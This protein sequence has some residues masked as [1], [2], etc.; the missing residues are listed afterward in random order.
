MCDWIKSQTAFVFIIHNEKAL[1]C[2]VRW[3][4]LRPVL[5]VQLQLVL[6]LG[7]L[8]YAMSTERLSQLVRV[9]EGNAYKP[10]TRLPRSSEILNLL[11]LP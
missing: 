2:H 9:R 4:T 8:I 3:A 10:P 5:L 7:L 1:D 6:T 11:Y